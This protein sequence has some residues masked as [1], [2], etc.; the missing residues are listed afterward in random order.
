M[1]RYPL[2]EIKDLLNSVSRVNSIGAF[3][4]EK[5][6]NYTQ[7]LIIKYLLD[8]GD[9]EI[10]QKE[11]ENVLGIRKSTISGVLDT[12]E[13]NMIIT[14]GSSS[15]DGREKIVMLSSTALEY[16]DK[17]LAKMERIEE[18]LVKDI[19]KEDLDAFYRVLDIMKENVKKKGN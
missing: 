11:F 10:T 9:K 3:F 6:A 15:Q 16:K 2:K 18:D 17:I 4:G 8:N 19:D 12:M 13:K 1:K 7:L 14:R 5:N